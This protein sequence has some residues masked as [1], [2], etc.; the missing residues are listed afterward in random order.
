MKKI[1][2]TI[3]MLALLVN[4]ADARKKD[5]AGNVENG[6]YLD[7][8]YNYSIGVPD[9]WNYS[10]RK[11]DSKLRMTMTKKQYDIPIHFQNAPNYTTAPKISIYVDTTSLTVD[12]FIDSLTSDKFKSKQKGAMLPE[13]KILNGPFQQKKRAKMIIGDLSGVKIAGQQKYTVQVQ[14]SGSQSDQADVCSDFF[15]GSIFFLK[16]GNLIIA[17]HMICEWRY[18]DVNENDFQEILNTL[19][20]I[21]G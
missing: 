2:M 17:I 14:R 8:K 12:Q 21:K 15:G 20:I 7:E 10:I 9:G 16:E 18:F 1:L 3:V 4:F 13:M 19:K 11:N 5:V 6:V